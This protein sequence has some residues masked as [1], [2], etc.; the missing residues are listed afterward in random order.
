MILNNFSAKIRSAVVAGMF[1]PEYEKELRN[2]VQNYLQ[3]AGEA[4]SKLNIDMCEITKIRMLIVPHAGYN[5]SGNSW[6][7]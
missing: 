2:A 3:S 1:Y 7:C 4:E 5:Y 6:K